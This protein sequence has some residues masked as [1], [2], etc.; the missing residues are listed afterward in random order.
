MFVIK[1]TGTDK[2]INVRP[3]FDSIDVKVSGKPVIFKVKSNADVACSNAMS[4]ITNAIAVN[5]A[6]I[7]ESKKELIR[8]VVKSNRVIDKIGATGVRPY[9]EVV[10][11]MNKLI[12]ERARIDSDIAQQEQNIVGCKAT[13][14]R[15]NK[16]QSTGFSVVAI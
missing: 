15:L 6:R 7:V 13:L 3:Y 16:I 4:Y 2:F 11:I 12:K 8:L 1:Q 5:T 14:Q 10:E 9:N